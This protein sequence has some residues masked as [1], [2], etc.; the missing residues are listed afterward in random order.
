MACSGQV[1]ESGI[2]TSK[3]MSESGYDLT[4]IAI[5]PVKLAK[6]RV[7]GIQGSVVHVRLRVAMCLPIAPAAA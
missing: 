1:K 4:P 3:L 6:V 2:T 7:R 5:G